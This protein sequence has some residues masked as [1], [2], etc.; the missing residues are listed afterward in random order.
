VLGGGIVSAHT[1]TALPVNEIFETVQGEGFW[2]GTPATFLRLQGCAVG[3]PWCDTKFTWELDRRMEIEPAAVLTKNQSGAETWAL[4]AEAEIAAALALTRP[5]LVVITGG[6]PA[7]YDLLELTE[8][9]GETAK[10]PQ[11][12]TSGT[13]L[14]R[15]SADT[16][17]TV[18]PKIGMPGGKPICADAIHRANEI[19]MVVGKQEDAERLCELL[20]QFEVRA[21]VPIFVQ[22]LSRSEKATR[23]CVKVATDMGWR[24]SLQTHALAGWR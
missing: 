16:W 24:V 13:E 6:E 5:D 23:L 22:P 21:G 18:S 15:V 9:I 2:T 11:L 12:E 3:C 19:K 10:R 20:T 1:T 14:P 17:V 4:M 8:L 7:L